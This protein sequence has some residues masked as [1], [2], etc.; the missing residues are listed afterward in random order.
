MKVLKGLLCLK[1]TARMSRQVASRHEHGMK[2]AGCTGFSLGQK[3][4][5]HYCKVGG[6]VLVVAIGV[7]IFCRALMSLTALSA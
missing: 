3:L 6:A 4:F 5:C 1:T 7:H 2:K